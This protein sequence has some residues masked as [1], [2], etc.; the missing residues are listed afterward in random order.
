MAKLGLSALALTDANNLSGI[1]GFAAAA[2]AAQMRGVRAPLHQAVPADPRLSSGH[3]KFGMHACTFR[4]PV[5][6]S[7]DPVTGRSRLARMLSM[8]STWAPR[9]FGRAAPICAS[10]QFFT[11][12]Q[13]GE[14]GQALRSRLAP[15]GRCRYRRHRMRGRGRSAGDHM[16]I[17]T[18]MTHRTGSAC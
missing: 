6:P 9:P 5:G 8:L 10:A 15:I 3:R 16:R 2:K 7:P 12:S 14:A 18:S 1:V 13:L 11:R 4:D 17:G